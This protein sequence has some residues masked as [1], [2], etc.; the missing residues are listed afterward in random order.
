MRSYESYQKE[1]ESVVLE[2]L[3]TGPYIL[4]EQVKAFEKEFAKAIGVEHCIGFG[5]GLEAI[6]LGIRALNIGPGDEVIV[7][8]NTYIATV[9]GVTQNGA[10]PVFVEPGP[11]YNID[12]IAIEKNITKRTK[13]ILVT[14]LYGQAT[15]MAYIQEICKSRGIILL[16]SRVEYRL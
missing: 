13:A 9:L 3:R 12:A 5:N 16:N 4:G 6:M 14:H 8:A 1:I 10:V 7:Q 11:Y 15:E 2:V